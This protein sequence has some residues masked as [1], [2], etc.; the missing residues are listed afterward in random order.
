M[1]KTITLAQKREWNFYI[2]NAFVHDFYHTWYYHA[3]DHS[4]MAMLF[5]YEEG[6]DY[7]AFPV[8]KRKIPGAVFFDLSS[9]Y[10]YVGPIASKDNKYLN[11]NF[12]NN[13]KR[14][15]LNF[16]KSEQIVSV[17]SRLNPFL[18]QDPLVGDFKGVY[19]NG[20]TVVLDLTLPI[21][22]QRK[23]YNSSVYDSI[24]KSKK[25][26]SLLRKPKNSRISKHLSLSIPRIWIA[27]SQL[28]ITVLAGNISLT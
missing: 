20:K 25:K 4:G 28:I 9:V 24:K 3:L 15:F 2:N 14:E 12:I 26:V 27:Y 10:G 21:D 22:E 6:Q 19:E 8:V 13:F 5:V 1:I 17:F 23:K 11:Q 7:I 18:N 16:L